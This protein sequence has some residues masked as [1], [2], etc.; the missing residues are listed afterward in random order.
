VELS[1]LGTMRSVAEATGLATS[2]VSQQLA[3]LEREAGAALLERV[4]R[5]VRLTPA[6]RRLV[7]HGV[8]ILAALE[9]ARADLDEGAEPSGL[10]RVASFASALSRVLLPLVRE[11]RTGHPHLRVELQEREPDEVLRLLHDDEVD[12]GITY[13]YNLAPRPEQPAMSIRPLWRTAWCLGVPDGPGG[14]AVGGS[15]QVVGSLR[16]TPWI[17]NSRGSDDEDVVRT[18]CALAGYRPHIGHRADNLELVQEMIAAGLGV[19]LLP[20]Q[21]AAQDGVR[22]VPLTDPRVE[23]RAYSVVRRGREHWPPLRFLA[24]RLAGDARAS[25]LQ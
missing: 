4:G 8:G 16:E 6:G 1:R 2:A 19:A 11:L 5:N 12:L 22:V 3:V 13:D 7:Q 17:V 9:I 21:M 20:E 15:P 14:P 23:H 18:L 10:V 25:L 24:E